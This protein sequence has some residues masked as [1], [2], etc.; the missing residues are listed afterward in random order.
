MVRRALDGIQRL[1]PIRRNTYLLLVAFWLI[2]LVVAFAGYRY[3]RHEKAAIE[4]EERMQLAAI[5]EL[6]VRQV[7]D[8]RNER[9]A[10]GTIVAAAPLA[11]SV[12][13]FLADGV[14]RAE[15]DREITA[16]LETIRSASAYANVILV[17]PA[18]KRWIGV[19]NTVSDPATYF[20]L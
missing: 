12:R 17:N 9:I 20:A 15:D 14:T 4:S 18:R 5:A 16:W 8:W 2:A 3:Y 11:Q 7:R 10:D 13:R 19:G 6:K 1:D